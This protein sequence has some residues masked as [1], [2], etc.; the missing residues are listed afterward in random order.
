MAKEVT[1][2]LDKLMQELLGICELIKE[3]NENLRK[4]GYNKAAAR[5]LR[6]LILGV[7]KMKKPIKE[8]MFSIER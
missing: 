2:E 4:G 7:E 1:P 3:E 5:R 8:E 6:K